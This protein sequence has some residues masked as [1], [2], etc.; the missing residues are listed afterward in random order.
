MPKLPINQWKAARRK[1]PT[2]RFLI[3]KMVV[4]SL[5]VEVNVEVSNT[6]DHWPPVSY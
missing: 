3:S 6:G 4:F 5:N 1:N 2:G